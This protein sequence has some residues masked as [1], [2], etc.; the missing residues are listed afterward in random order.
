MHCVVGCFL[1]QETDM[2]H[3]ADDVQILDVTGEEIDP[4]SKPID[5]GE[6][7]ELV[8]K[9]VMESRDS[10]C[11]ISSKFHDGEDYVGIYMPAVDFFQ[12]TSLQK[13]IDK[14]VMESQGLSD[15]LFN[16][17]NLMSPEEIEALLEQEEEG[18]ETTESGE[19]QEVD[20]WADAELPDYQEFPEFNEA[21]DVAPETEE[22]PKETAPE[23]GESDTPEEVKK[24][25][26][27][28]YNKSKKRK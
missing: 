4:D 13:E 20:I 10:K 9:S 16:D 8:T 26:G 25:T 1:N 22:A 18:T 6:L 24:E 11:F 27:K 7:A 23:P 28:K 17:E 12:Y 15:S 5:L 14:M 2:L 21:E 19:V 3:F